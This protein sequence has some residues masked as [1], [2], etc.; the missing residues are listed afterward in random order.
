MDFG[1]SHQHHLL[2]FSF[3]SLTSIFAQLCKFCLHEKLT[4]FGFYNSFEIRVV[5][6]FVLGR[7]TWQL[8]CSH[9]KN[10]MDGWYLCV[11][12]CP[13][14]RL[15]WAVLV[16]AVGET[17]SFLKYSRALG[18]L[19]LL[20]HWECGSS[21]SCSLVWL[22]L[23]FLSELAHVMLNSCSVSASIDCQIF[24]KNSVIA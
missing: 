21:S 1:F 19:K 13:H 5:E 23:F 22:C 12:I 17:L 16:E 10:K 6:A 18:C 24:L 2:V 20:V 15:L 7:C 8:S 3:R 9:R 11:R 4:L 14:Q